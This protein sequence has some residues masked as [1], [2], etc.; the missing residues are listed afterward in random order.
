MKNNKEDSVALAEHALKI[1]KELFDA[2][3]SLNHLESVKSR[4]DDFVEY[5][6]L[7]FRLNL[8]LI[9]CSFTES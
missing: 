1:T 9:Q 8:S 3:R 6:M 5:V 4:I 2:L 7:F